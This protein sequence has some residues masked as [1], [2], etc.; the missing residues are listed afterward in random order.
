MAFAG[1]AD[2]QVSLVIGLGTFSSLESIRNKILNAIQ[3]G[4]QNTIKPA[5]GYYF[6]MTDGEVNLEE[7]AFSERK[8]Y[9]SID[10]L[11]GEEIYTNNISG[12]NSLGGY[13]KIFRVFF[14]VWLDER[15]NL[16]LE[17]N[18]MIA[19]FE[20]YFG[21]N[22]KLPDSVGSQTAFNCILT[23]NVPFGMG[24]NRPRGG[25]DFLLEVYYRI[26]LTDPNTTF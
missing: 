25:V 12:G 7:K 24:D 16:K 23:R 14:E 9:P 4:L 2:Q 15:E 5:N 3:Y 20:K 10:I 13:N 19:D 6:D 17:Q 11:P 26:L 22:F 21:T 1:I 8:K 18:K